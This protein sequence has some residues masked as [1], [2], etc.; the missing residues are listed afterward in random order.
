MEMGTP[1]KTDEDKKNSHTPDLR[2]EDGLSIF[3]F[4]IQ[5]ILNTTPLGLEYKAI[6]P[7]IV[8]NYRRL[9]QF[10][11]YPKLEYQWLIEHQDVCKVYA[12]QKP[13]ETSQSDSEAGT[14]SL[15]L[16]M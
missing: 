16:P 3:I 1:L 9:E 14:L 8:L 5:H 10:E 4:Y 2:D 6:S 13:K 15:D 12:K 7:N 11:L